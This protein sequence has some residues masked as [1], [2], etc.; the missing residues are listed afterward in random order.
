MKSAARDGLI[1]TFLTN[2]DYTIVATLL[3]VA[4]LHGSTVST[5]AFSMAVSIRIV[6]SIVGMLCAPVV[7]SRIRNGN[8][9]MM[10]S[11]LKGLAFTVLCISIQFPAMCLFAILAG[12][13][14][15]ISKP[16]IRALLSNVS[17]VDTRAKIF[18]LFFVMMNAALVIG[19]FVAQLALAGND[20]HVFLITLACIEFLVALWIMRATRDI[21]LNI[22]MGKR[23]SITQMIGLWLNAKVTPILLLSFVVYFAMGFMLTGFLLYRDIVPGLSA[24]RETLLSFEAFATIVIQLA[25]MPIFR[26]I[27]R[28]ML[29]ALGIFGAG[30]G[31]FLSFASTLP[32]VVTGLVLFAFAECLLMP[33]TQLEVSRVVPS[34][35]TTAVFSAV[36]IAGAIGETFGSL[37]PGY[38]IQ[39]GA[40]FFPT[41]ASAAQW[42]ALPVFLVFLVSSLLVLRSGT[43]DHSLVATSSSQS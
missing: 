33:Q 15:G 13:G 22:S 37:A 1:F 28:P 41:V 17:T 2:I 10:A 7:F 4:I 14:T 5:A 9:L 6:A 25:L 21:D 39:S 35:Q 8:L 27:R 31:I 42:M 30:I 18:Q 12:L 26:K 38:V 16:A 29:Y 23:F 43:S 24:Y 40:T 20:E 11:I 19:P 32:V 34:S 3:P 36:T